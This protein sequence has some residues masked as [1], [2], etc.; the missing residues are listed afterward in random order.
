MGGGRRKGRKRS[1]GSRRG[2]RREEEGEKAVMNQN[3]MTRRNRN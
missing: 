1:R 3:H 2:R